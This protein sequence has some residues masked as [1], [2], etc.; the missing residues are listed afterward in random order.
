M[1]P[2][3][4]PGRPEAHKRSTDPTASKDKSDIKGN[5]SEEGNHVFM[6]ASP[7]FR[8]SSLP[9]LLRTSMVIALLHAERTATRWH[10]RSND[11]A[12]MALD[13]S[14]NLRLRIKAQLKGFSGL[15]LRE[16]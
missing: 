8:C 16:L 3:E 5:K 7:P 9:S 2:Q 12:A 6:S 14:S 15:Y 13:R 4:S 11:M 10:L 1:G